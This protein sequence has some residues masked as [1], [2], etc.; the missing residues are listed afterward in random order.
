MRTTVHT[1]LVRQALNRVKNMPFRWSLNPYR[2]CRHACAYCYARAT[3]R[4][5]D[6]SPDE[7]FSTVL[8]AKTNIAE[9]LGQEV[10]RPG[11][12]R[13]RVALGTATDP[14]QP[15]EGRYRLTRS[16]LYVLLEAHTP[17]DIVTK[18][19]LIVR[20]LDVLATMARRG[21]VRVWFSVPTVDREVWRRSEPGTPAP[22]HR[23]RALSRLRQAGVPCGVLVAPVLPGITDDPFHVRQA[24]HAAKEAGALAVGGRLLR[25][26]ERFYPHLTTAYD[27]W[28][29]AGPNAP[30]SLSRTFQTNFNRLRAEYGLAA[31][32]G[33]VVQPQITFGW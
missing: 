18:G 3:H 28:Y 22:V 11:W 5:L 23:L 8:Y 26:L 31:D 12:Q 29:R 7:D 2:G 32:F 14:Y 20:D 27:Q 10:R 17:V 25:L 33:K 24:V 30:P 9:V 15:L 6:L 4:F 19:T 1:I 21:L 13:E 16:C